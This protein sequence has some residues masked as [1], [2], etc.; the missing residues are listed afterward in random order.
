MFY[1]LKRFSESSD[2]LIIKKNL[3]WSTVIY[4]QEDVGKQSEIN[5]YLYAGLVSPVEGAKY[6]RLYKQNLWDGLNHF[7]DKDSNSFPTGLTNQVCNLIN[8]KYGV[9]YKVV[10]NEPDRFI[11]LKDLPEKMTLADGLGKSITLRD[12]QQKAVKSIIENGY[13]IINASVNAG[14]SEIAAAFIKLASPKTMNDERIVYFT[15][16]KQIFSQTVERLKKRLNVPIGEFGAGK[17]VIRPITVAMIQTV[18]SYLTIDP[19]KK[20]S[21]TEKERVYKKINQIYLPKFSNCQNPR[22][23]LHSFVQL[24]TP[25]TK[26]DLKVKQTLEDI[27]YEAGSNKQVIAKIK[28]YADMYVDAI[29]KKNGDKYNK[30]KFIDDFLSSAVVIIADECLIGDTTVMMNN[31]TFKKIKDVKKGDILAHNNEVTGTIKHTNQGVMTVIHE[32][33]VFTGTITH[34]VFTYDIEHGQTVKKVKAISQ[35]KPGDRIFVATGFNSS[36]YMLSTVKSVFMETGKY[37][38]YDLE[39]KKGS[40]IGNGV[41]QHNCHHSRSDTWYKVL[42]ACENSI[43]RVGLS[44]TIDTSDMT[45]WMRLQAVFGGIISR[46]SAKNL[47]DR[48]I[49]AKPVINM[50]KINKP[51]NL[52]ME[53]DWHKVY[54]E[55]IVDNDYRNKVICQ[56]AKKGYEKHQSILIIVNQ[57]EHAN[58]LATIFEDLKVPYEIINGQQDDD[59]REQ[60]LNRLRDGETKVLIATSVLD[61]GVDVANINVLILAAGGK[62]FRQTVQRVG[63]V[64]RKKTKGANKALVLDFIDKQSP[65]LYNHSNNRKKIYEEEQFDVKVI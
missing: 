53:K 27:Y 8:Q 5:N 45:T 18:E 55:G 50:I 25:K 40:F 57:I 24:Y 4:D 59:T 65:Y 44:G 35:L 26:I 46:V 21:L 37:D 41:L 38:V 51:D 11:S 14:K 33:G 2:R 47:I 29:K 19:E 1:G 23:A 36:S 60:E 42:L 63:R 15:G 12:Y 10:D 22:Q 13:G 30:R 20:V 48:G 43:Y 64:I 31:Y 28:E 56:L 7:Y 54:K 49:S 39:T 16:S 58:N 3:S 52:Q 32:Q 62:S 34:P 61:E 9:I 6:S 17:K